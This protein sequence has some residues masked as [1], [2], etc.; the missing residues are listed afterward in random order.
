MPDRSDAD[1][2]RRRMWPGPHPATLGARL[3]LIAL[4]GGLS[5]YA[6]GDP[7]MVFWAAL[8]ALIGIPAVLAPQHPFI[9][10]LS[11]VAEVLVTVLG[12]DVVVGHAVAGN[13][14]FR[15][16]GAAAAMLPYLLVPIVA[17]ALYRR[18]V[19]AV[20]LLGLATAL[21]LTLAFVDVRAAARSASLV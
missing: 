19:E 21:T 17:A 13:A 7:A 14:L 4:V 20:A 16:G 9:G 3:L 18:R 11:R 12:A 2:D 15:G 6:T 10:P 1:P 8:L 5:V